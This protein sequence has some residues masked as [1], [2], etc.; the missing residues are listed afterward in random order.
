[1]PFSVINKNHAVIAG[2]LSSWWLTGIAKYPKG[3]NPQHLYPQSTVEQSM[4]Y[5][6][7]HSVHTIHK[8][9]EKLSTHNS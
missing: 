8:K 2:F 3:A 7:F 6:G 9:V 4:A 5:T 1:L